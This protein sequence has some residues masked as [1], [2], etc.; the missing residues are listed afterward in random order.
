[1]NINKQY[2]CRSAEGCRE[3]NPLSFLGNYEDW[4]LGRVDVGKLQ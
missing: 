1:M 2:A 4:L 3:N